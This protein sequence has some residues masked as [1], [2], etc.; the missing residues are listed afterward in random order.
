[1][2]R[3]RYNI[4]ATLGHGGGYCATLFTA[5][6]HFIAMICTSPEGYQQR[7]PPTLNLGP[8]FS[9]WPCDLFPKLCNAWI[10]FLSHGGDAQD[11]VIVSGSVL[12]HDDGASGDCAPRECREQFRSS[13]CSGQSLRYQQ[14]LGRYN[15][16]PPPTCAAMKKLRR[17][18]VLCAL[19]ICWACQTKDL[20]FCGWSRAESTYAHRP[21]KISWGKTHGALA[22]GDSANRGHQPDQMG[23]FLP[24]IDLGTGR[25]ATSLTTG[26]WEYTMCAVLDDGN[27]KCWG[28]NEHGQCGIGTDTDV[29]GVGFDGTSPV[30]MLGTGRTVQQVAGGFYSMC[31]LLDGGSVKCWG[32]GLQALG[33]GDTT[34]RGTNVNELGE[35]LPEVDFGT[36]K[37][38]KA[39][40]SGQGSIC[41]ILTDDST[42]C[43][44]KWQEVPYGDSVMRG[45]APGQMGDNL[46]TIDFGTGRHAT[47][48]GLGQNMGCAVL[49]DG[50]VKCWSD[51][52]A[53]NKAA[54][55]QDT[56]GFV[57]GDSFPAI[58]WEL[59]RSLSKLQR[60]F[61]IPVPFSTTVP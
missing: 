13:R 18:A 11:L 27:A 22:Q 50:G 9:I 7:L 10:E 15:T 46:P 51:N 23:D 56:A 31:A 17:A 6:Q 25:T 33:F 61:N 37:V 16:P 14:M 35:N 3:I 32:G 38:A 5:G 8:C 29:G 41:V 12:P 43:W 60:G 1:M 47:H 36:G 59:E 57:M 19:A 30:A 39:L 45:T 54:R 49:D 44:G 52:T 58:T 40:Y 42:K 24:P 21:M 34:T 4:C 20:L 48:I 53:T 26:P 55:G 2:W 28:W